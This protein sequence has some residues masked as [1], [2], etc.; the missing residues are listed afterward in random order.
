MQLPL[1]QV[2]KS[3][4]WLF[5]AHIVVPWSMRPL[6]A[7]TIQPQLNKGCWMSNSTKW[8]ITIRHTTLHSS[9]TILTTPMARGMWRMQPQP[10]AKA[11]KEATT[12]KEGTTISKEVDFKEEDFKEATKLSKGD[13]KGFKALTHFKEKLPILCTLK[14]P[15][16][17]MPL[18]DK[19]LTKHLPDLS[20]RGRTSKLKQMI[21]GSQHSRRYSLPSLQAN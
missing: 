2:N 14:K 5:L 21:Q 6:I 7:N 4:Q 19:A 16:P 8:I 3:R 18:K 9:T 15:A 20:T 13:H 17:H 12:I 10:T 1:I 11:T